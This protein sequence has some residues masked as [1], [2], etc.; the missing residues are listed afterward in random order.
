MRYNLSITIKLRIQEALAASILASI[1]VTKPVPLQVIDFW[2]VSLPTH[3]D[4]LDP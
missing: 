1:I 2:K 4:N 3:I